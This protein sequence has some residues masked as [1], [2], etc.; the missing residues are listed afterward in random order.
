MESGAGTEF[1]DGLSLESV[2]SEGVLQDPVE[3]LVNMVKN[4][5]IDPWCVDI[6]EVADKFLSRVREMERLDLRVSGRTLFYASVLLRMKS[7]VLVE[8][9]EEEEEVDFFDGLED[10][11]VED[12]PLPQ[13][14]LR[15][16]SQRPVTLDELISELKKA[17]VVERR[18]RARSSRRS[19]VEVETTEEVLGIAHE[20]NI[21]E[22]MQELR[23]RL[24]E[25]FKVADEVSFS[26]LVSCNGDDPVMTFLALLFLA[27][28]REIWLEQQ[29]L[30]G[31]LIIRSRS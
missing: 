13:L 28:R 1:V 19:V 6:V 12:Y 27:G 9:D 5:E 31:E 10:F 26:R 18:R 3:L 23:G 7:N 30:F 17:E 14:P 22:R 11:D 24:Q 15:R 21:E 16:R 2:D 4:G 29:E 25:I 8:P 20:E